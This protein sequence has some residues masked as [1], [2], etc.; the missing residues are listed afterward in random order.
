MGGPDYPSPG[1]EERRLQTEQ[2]ELLRQQRDLLQEQLRQQQLLAPILFEESG[3]LPQ[4]N[5][6]GQITGFQ[7]GPPTPEQ[8]LAKQQLQLASLTLPYTLKQSGLQAQ[9]D[10]EGNI[11]G[12]TEIADPARDRRAQIQQA[13]DER[14]L[15]ALAGNL[16]VD[17]A[18]ERNLG[19]GR[20]TLLESLEQQ[21]GPG[22]VT[23]TPGIQ[24]L[25]EYDKRAE[26]LRYGARTGQLTLS[27]QLSLAESS[28]GRGLAESNI[29]TLLRSLQGPFPG[30]TNNE[31]TTGTLGRYAASVREPFAL[32][33]GT[34]SALG[35][36]A[37]RYSGFYAPFA[38]QRQGE[39]DAA[40]ARNRQNVQTGAAI[41]G[42]IG[43]FFGPVGTAV[44]GAAGSIAGSYV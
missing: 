25:A 36:L 1:P 24:S 21:L 41:G 20:T 15:A 44:G 3:L 5:E 34:G 43:S 6:S 42:L 8:R 13:L 17:P 9:Y 26:E 4:Y 22:A 30:L 33:G 14:T 32:G 29:S 27:E 16:P 39:F 35:D 12:V 38:Q 37:S 18:L 10:Q 7:K 40:T 2:A 28:Q 31:G 23:S 11:V 19:T